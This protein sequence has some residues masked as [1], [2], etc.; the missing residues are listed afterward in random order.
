MLIVQ[1]SG[2]INSEEYILAECPHPAFAKKP[3]TKLLKEWRLR[4][5]EMGEEPT[6][7]VVPVELKFNLN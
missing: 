3:L 6:D 7:S 2:L 5:A 4:P 1:K